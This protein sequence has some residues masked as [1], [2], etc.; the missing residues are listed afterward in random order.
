[1]DRVDDKKKKK[2]VKFTLYAPQ[3]I[4]A[5]LDNLYSFLGLSYL[6]RVQRKVKMIKAELIIAII[7]AFRCQRKYS[8]I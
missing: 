8:R 6:Q 3:I 2:L 5:L 1:L 4:N 7:Y